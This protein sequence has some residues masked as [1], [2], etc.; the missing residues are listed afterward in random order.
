[1]FVIERFVDAEII[2][3][4]VPGK[5]HRALRSGLLPYLRERAIKNCLAL[6]GKTSRTTFLVQTK[7]RD[8]VQPGNRTT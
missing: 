7:Y 4:V 6:H 5:S 8:R 2:S 1:M 3:L